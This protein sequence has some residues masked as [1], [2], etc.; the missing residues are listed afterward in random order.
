MN[1]TFTISGG[2][3]A[4][5]TTAIALKRMGIEALVVEAA[6]EFK[7]VGAGIV[8]AANAMRAYR[9][10]G[11]YDQLVAAGNP[12]EQA[13]IYDRKGKVINRLHR[14]ML[15]VE[16]PNLAIH[17][18]ELH[19]VL[20]AE[21]D[22]GQILT[23]KRSRD[24]I[25]DADGHKVIYEDGSEIDTRYLIVAEGINSPIRKK[26]LPASETRYAGY[27]CWR[28]IADN[29]SL[30]VP[31]SSETW[32]ARGRFG[33]VP[34][35]HNQLYWFATKN[36]PAG[37]L[38]MLSWGIGELAENFKDYHEPI[39]DVIRASSHLIHNDLYDLKPIP[40]FAFGKVLLIGDAA[41]ATTPNMGQGACMAIEDAVILANCLRKNPV[42]KYAFSDFEARRVKRT[43]GIVNQSWRLGRIAQVENALVAG[44]RNFIVRN[45]PEKTYRDQLEKL[46]NV[47]LD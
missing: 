47:D 40:R 16:A 28:G 39:P 45:I 38:A 18:A 2:G 41:H 37:S 21:L 20:L 32:G 14:N 22:P 13:T 33:V 29:A 24:V 8:L 9:Q 26:L 27:T 44:V 11:I 15:R 12:I 5:L 43:H 10:L 1:P 25:I 17:R 31:E 23:G 7:P 46:Y 6:P 19:R 42:V 36:A 4:G 3:I 35:G 34:I 30:K